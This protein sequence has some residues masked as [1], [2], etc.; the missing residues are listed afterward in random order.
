MEEPYLNEGKLNDKKIWVQDFELQ[1]RRFEFFLI[2]K[3]VICIFKNLFIT[4]KYII[5]GL[6][7]QNTIK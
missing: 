5:S 3:N 7:I 2:K 1:K 6:K 4:I